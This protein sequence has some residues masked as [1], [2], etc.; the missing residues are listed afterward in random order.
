MI[1]FLYIYEKQ[2][3]MKNIYKLFG[4]FL[5]FSCFGFTNVRTDFKYEIACDII[6][7]NKEQKTYLLNVRVIQTDLSNDQQLLISSENAAINYKNTDELYDNSN[8]CKVGLL[9]NG[10][11]IFPDNYNYDYCL[12]DL[13]ANDVALYGKY[14]TV[15]RDL[16]NKIENR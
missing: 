12:K 13:L 9:E 11:F 4:I 3:I 10:D 8:S 7:Y 6:S 16:M 2:L 1:N 15:T 5:I 14:L